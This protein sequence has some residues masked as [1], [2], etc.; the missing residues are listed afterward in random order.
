MDRATVRTA[1][2]H[3]G[4]VVLLEGDV[5]SAIGAQGAILSSG[6]LAPERSAVDDDVSRHVAGHGDDIGE[7]R[8]ARG[9]VLAVGEA[10]VVAIVVCH[11][12]VGGERRDVAGVLHDVG[13][14]GPD[15]L[16]AE[17]GDTAVVRAARARAGAVGTR[18][19]TA[20][21]DVGRGSVAA[22]DLDAVLAVV[23][24]VLAVV[25]LGTDRS[26]GSVVAASSAEDGDGEEHADEASR[27]VVDGA[28]DDAPQ[29]GERALDAHCETPWSP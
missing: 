5:R 4:A 3:V 21:V 24:D 23:A 9:E 28:E 6:L 16:A 25:A 13:L 22:G 7:G 11:R 19:V 26:D 20:V 12:G 27:V 8:V 15:A 29:R 10:P 14:A 2:E 17:L 1:D 18:A